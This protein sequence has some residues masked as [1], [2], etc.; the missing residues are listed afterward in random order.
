MPTFTQ[1]E[2]NL[3]FIHGNDTRSSFIH[4]DAASNGFPLFFV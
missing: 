4:I 1:E 2:I 3:I